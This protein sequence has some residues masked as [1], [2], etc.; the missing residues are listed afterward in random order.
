MGHL[1]AIITTVAEVFI[2]LVA[3]AVLTRFVIR[4][5]FAEKEKHL[6]SLMQVSQHDYEQKNEKGE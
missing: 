1:D 2:A 5:Y 6:A 3:T 4:S